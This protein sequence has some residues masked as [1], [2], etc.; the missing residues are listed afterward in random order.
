MVLRSEVAMAQK[1]GASIPGTAILTL[2]RL[3]GTEPG[4]ATI[5]QPAANVTKNMEITTKSY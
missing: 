5:G 4:H 2:K 3:V 1:P